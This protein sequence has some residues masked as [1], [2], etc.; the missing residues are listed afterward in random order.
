MDPPITRMLVMTTVRAQGSKIRIGR[1]RSV[2]KGR[3][4]P[5][6]LIFRSNKI[7]VGNIE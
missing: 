2:V 4:C 7:R 1:D 6:L 5:L 3:G